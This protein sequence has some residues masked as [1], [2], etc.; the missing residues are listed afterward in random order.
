MPLYAQLYKLAATDFFVLKG[1]NEIIARECV[2]IN[3]G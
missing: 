3:A 1:Y 2:N